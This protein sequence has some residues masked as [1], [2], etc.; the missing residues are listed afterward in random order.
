MRNMSPRNNNEKY[1]ALRIDYMLEKIK[2]KEYGSKLLKLH[3]ETDF[4][5]E[6][7]YTFDLLRDCFISITQKMY[8][9][10]NTEDFQDDYKEL[11]QL[12]KYYLKITEDIKNVYYPNSSGGIEFGNSR[13]KLKNLIPEEVNSL[14]LLRGKVGK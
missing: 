11:V 7:A 2:E 12:G 5:E 1:V 10:K 6:I 9:R 3:K 4:R 8:S 13:K 14:P